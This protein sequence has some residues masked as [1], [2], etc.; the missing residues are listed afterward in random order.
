M[1]FITQVPTVW[2]YSRKSEFDFS[3]LSMEKVRLDRCMAV[4]YSGH[5][6]AEFLFQL[7]FFCD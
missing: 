7:S 5:N 2:N 3:P 1:I 6:V 4:F